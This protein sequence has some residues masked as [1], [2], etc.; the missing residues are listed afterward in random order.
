MPGYDKND[1]WS[2]AKIGF[3]EADEDHCRRRAAEER[4]KGLDA[5]DPRVR[6]VHLDMAARYEDIARAIELFEHHL[7]HRL[8]ALA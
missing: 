3:Q 2:R 8:D 5:C 6:Q 1:A 7:D 4:A